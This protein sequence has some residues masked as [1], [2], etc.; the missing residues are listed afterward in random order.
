[1]L[2]FQDLSIQRKLTLI[3]TLVST[4]ALLVAC[5]A[6]TA[7]ELVSSRRDTA[8]RLGS[9]GDV[10]AAGSAAP[11]AFKDK[12]AAEETLASL[13]GQNEIAAACLY[14]RDGVIF[15]QRL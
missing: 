13:R 5:G 3:A 2:R 6:F 7:Y 9:L 15:A 8:S 14:A 12:P 11:L 1:M 10:I 4:L